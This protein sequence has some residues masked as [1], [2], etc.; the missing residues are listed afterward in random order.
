MTCATMVLMA[1]K[2][3]VAESAPADVVAKMLANLAEHGFVAQRLFPKQD[4]PKLAS[5]YVIRGEPDG[6][7]PAVK[8]VLAPFGTSTVEYVEG[9][10]DRHIAGA[11]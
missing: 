4:R 8:A 11:G 7:L 1:I 10:V 3:K 6:S 9:G 2:F 5:I